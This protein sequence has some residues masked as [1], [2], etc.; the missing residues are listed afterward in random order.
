MNVRDRS[1]TNSGGEITGH[2][3]LPAAPV[4]KSAVIPP[5]HDATEVSI[6]EGGV[7]PC[8]AEYA[9]R[10]DGSVVA[11]SI[12]HGPAVGLSAGKCADQLQ[13]A[14]DTSTITQADHLSTHRGDVLTPLTK[15]ESA[16]SPVVLNLGRQ[17]MSNN[18]VRSGPT[19]E[20]PSSSTGVVARVGKDG[21]VHGPAIASPTGDRFG[22][23]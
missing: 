13:R 6:V 22:S 3:P 2:T 14:H 8:S 15:A 20:K 19:L 17:P 9:G 12:V 1:M 4:P 21:V 16:S 11:K 23:V 7:E 5:N 18:I 10:G